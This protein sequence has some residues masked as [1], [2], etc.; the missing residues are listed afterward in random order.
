MAGEKGA[1]LNVQ[2][3]SIQGRISALTN[4][5]ELSYIREEDPLRAATVQA[6][7]MALDDAKHKVAQAQQLIDRLGA[8]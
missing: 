1:S 4:H 2:A 6:A 3:V 7:Q 8:T 5:L